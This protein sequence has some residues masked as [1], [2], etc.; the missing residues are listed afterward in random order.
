MPL[1]SCSS[2]MG[3]H[4]AG[5][6]S[7]NM[8]QGFPFIRV[9]GYCKLF[10]PEPRLREINRRL[11]A[12]QLHR[13]LTSCRISASRPHCVIPYGAVAG[14]K[15]HYALHLSSPSPEAIRILS[16][17]TIARPPKRS[18]GA[19]LTWLGAPHPGT[20][21]VSVECIFCFQGPLRGPENIPSQ[22]IAGEKPKITGKKSQNR[23]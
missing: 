13:P 23:W 19:P 2:S 3:W 22:W 10:F 8:E 6:S 15:Y 11:A 4:K 1:R 5:G 12:D 7:P 17:G 9:I 14:R 20:G 21:N 18:L 16:N